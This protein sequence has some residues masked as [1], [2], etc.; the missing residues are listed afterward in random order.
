MTLSSLLRIIGLL[1]IAGVC[2]T[3]SD[4]AQP[5]VSQPTAPE[6]SPSRPASEEVG[7]AV[8]GPSRAPVRDS[9]PPLGPQGKNASPSHGSQAPVRE[10]S[11]S[12]PSWDQR[13]IEYWLEQLDDDQFARRQA[14]T[15]QLNHFGQQ[16]VEPLVL[17]AQSGKLELT[18]RAVGILQSLA[19]EQAPDDEG[20]AWAALSGLVSQGTGSAS[21]GARAAIEDIRRERESQAHAKLAAAGVQIGFREFVLHSRALN[22]EVVWIDKKWKG[23]V[24]AL[25]WLRWIKR[26]DY[27]L[28]E[29]DAVRQEV[30]QHVVQMPDLR[31]IVM[32]DATIRDDIYE[33][34]GKLARIDELEFRYIPLSVEDAEKIARL[35][36]RVSLGLMG[37]GM[38]LEGAKKLRESI[39]GLNLVYKQGGFLGVVC[40]SFSNRCQID[41]VKVGGAAANAGLQAGDVIIQIDEKPIATFDDLQLQIGS[42]LPDDEIEITYDRLGEIGTVKL[43]LGRLEGE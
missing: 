4:A 16:A 37:T 33:P 10:S 28:I 39:P 7:P 20:G 26:I 38:P 9:S 32:R 12:R 35:P 41:A 36:L 40:N 23:D 27:A 1:L 6:S 11:P 2:F 42:H 19:R 43:K 14:A 21:V 3:G 30:L 5:P 13:P 18:Q 31:S 24:D 8:R 29:G 22:H 25:R 17:V 34:L 15:R